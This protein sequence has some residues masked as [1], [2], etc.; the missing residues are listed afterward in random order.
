MTVSVQRDE[1]PD[2]LHDPERPGSRKEPV[3]AGE[4][5]AAGEG[6]DEPGMATLEGVHDHHERDGGGAESSEHETS[7]T[8]RSR[9]LGAHHMDSV[10]IVSSEAS[11]LLVIQPSG[12]TR[13]RLI[14]RAQTLS[15]LSIGWMT[16]EAGVAIVAA[17]IA[18]SVALLGFGLDSLIELASA[19]TI[20]WLYTGSRSGSDAAERRAQQLI[21]IC[22][23]ALAVYVSF[24]AIDTLARG[25]H[26]DTSWP[27]CGGGWGDRLHAVAS[28]RQGPRRGA[29]R[30]RGD[31]RGRCAV[32]AVR[33][34]RRRR[35]PQHSRQRP[36]GLVVA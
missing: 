17:L 7:L 10:S 23:A 32:V 26:P 28:S 16:V 18:G 29:A 19:G 11:R 24:D 15:L 30:L 33:D 2:G 14:R 13:A 36:I 1:R 8:M 5:A 22:F 3:D 4:S 34:L 27:G 12:K 6:E 35:A 21:A 31:R 20:L 9:A 25:A